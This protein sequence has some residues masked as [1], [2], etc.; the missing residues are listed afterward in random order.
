MMWGWTVST[1]IYIYIYIYTWAKVLHILKEAKLLG[2]LCGNVAITYISTQ[3]MYFAIFLPKCYCFGSLHTEKLTMIHD[4][5]SPAKMS[6][7]QLLVAD[8]LNLPQ[9]DYSFTFIVSMP[10]KRCQPISMY[11]MWHIIGLWRS[12]LK[13]MD[14]LNQFSDG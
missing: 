8:T 4:K 6:V 12:G 3:H 14:I 9:W 13:Q 2:N 10:R 11:V 1:I 5:M 7:C